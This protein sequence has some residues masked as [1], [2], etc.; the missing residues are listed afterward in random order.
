MYQQMIQRATGC[1]EAEA[2][3]AEDI[4]RHD[5]FHSTLDW[6]SRALFDKAARLAITVVR[7]EPILAAHARAIERGTAVRL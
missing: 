7:G 1:T 5:I 4:M 3:A 6:Q 2:C